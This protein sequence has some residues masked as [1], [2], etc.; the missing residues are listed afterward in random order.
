[1]ISKFSLFVQVG[2]VV[3][4]NY[5]PYAGKTAVIVEII[6]QNRALVHGPTTGVPRSQINFKWIQLTKLVVNISKAARESTLVKALKAAD[7]DNKVA[8]IAAVKK[9]NALAAKNATTDFE[10]FKT[11][12]AKRTV[13]KKVV[14]EFRKIVKQANRAT[15]TKNVAQKK[16]GHVKKTK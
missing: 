16:A 12:L 3:F 4:I 14:T 5:G 9:V 8:Q 15:H 10:R 13:N 7:F 1:M 2:R 11:R 6:D